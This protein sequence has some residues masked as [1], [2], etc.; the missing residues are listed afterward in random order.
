MRKA[1]PNLGDDEFDQKVIEAELDDI[2][3]EFCA[4]WVGPAKKPPA[5]A[6]R[7]TRCAPP[8]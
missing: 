4:R 1:N 7:R 3:E 5:E 8:R 6:C 2:V